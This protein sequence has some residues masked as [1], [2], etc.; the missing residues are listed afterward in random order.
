MKLLLIISAAIVTLLGS[1]VAQA[2][3]GD[4]AYL[5]LLN[6]LYQSQDAPSLI[7]LGHSVCGALSRG[8]TE[9]AVITDLRQTLPATTGFTGYGGGVPVRCHRGC[10]AI[11]VLP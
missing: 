4:A 3:S 10:R 2:D 7:R 8:V 1:P 9:D 6:G 11:R 5:R